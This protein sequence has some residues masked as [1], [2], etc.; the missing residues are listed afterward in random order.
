MSVLPMS[1]SQDA[2]REEA[3]S[4]GAQRCHKIA[5]VGSAMDLARTS[6]ALAVMAHPMRLKMLLVI[7][8]GEIS[9]LNIAMKLGISPGTAS[10]HLTLL[11]NNGVV[12]SRRDAARVYYRVTDSAIPRVIATI[13]EMQVP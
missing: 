2:T 5:L 4:L 8:K 3:E 11:R 12:A 10:K 1:S 6:R 9:V 13:C 7:S